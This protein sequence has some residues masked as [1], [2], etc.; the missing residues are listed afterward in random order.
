MRGIIPT[1]TVSSRPA[2]LRRGSE[3]FA[4]CAALYAYPATLCRGGKTFATSQS[5]AIAALVAIL[6]CLLSPILIHAAP[7]RVYLRDGRVLEGQILGEQRGQYTF[8]TDGKQQQ[9]PKG[10][11][12]FVLYGDRAKAD[13]FLGLNRAAQQAKGSEDTAP[14]RI[15]PAE[16]FGEA[17]VPAVQSATQ[18]IWIAAYYISGNMT[19]P[20]KE[21]YD[22]IR[23][24]A[25]AGLDVVLV[26]EYSTDTRPA[27]R[28]ATQNF[29]Q[30]E[31]ARDGVTVLLIQGKKTMHKKMII[32]DGNT[33]L[34]GSSNLTVAGTVGSNEMNVR[35]DSPAFARRAMADFARLRALALPASGLR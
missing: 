33:V 27:V 13:Q 32:V 2:T 12:K 35:I 6:L 15:L 30:E 26:C 25:L 31:L 28:M 5:R 21:F 23:Q 7:D 29:A 1:Q 4:H 17:I 19:G 20:I 14:V 22:T 9:M 3:T 10:S 8:L 11:V 34:L 24:K 16:G 18:S